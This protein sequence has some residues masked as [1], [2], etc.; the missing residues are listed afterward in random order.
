MTK[1]LNFIEVPTL[2]NERPLT[3][4]NETGYM[5]SKIGKSIFPTGNDSQAKKELCLW[6]TSVQRVGTSSREKSRIHHYCLDVHLI[7]WMY[8]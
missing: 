5:F 2:E 8:T 6:H 4:K 7:A 3:G 1:G